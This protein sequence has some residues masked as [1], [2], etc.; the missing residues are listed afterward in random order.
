[1]KREDHYNSFTALRLLGAFLVLLSHSFDLLG[2]SEP[3]DEYIGI[4]F[5]RLGLWIFF[6]ISGYLIGSSAIYSKNIKS[7]F[8]KR[9]LRIF[10][11]LIVVVLVSLSLLGPMFTSYSI[12]EYF[13][14]GSTYS[15]F[16]NI[17]LYRNHYSLPGVFSANPEGNVI[18]GSLWTLAY[19]FSFYTLASALVLLPK[20]FHKITCLSLIIITTTLYVMGMNDSSL[21]LPFFHLNFKHL[22]EFGILFAMGAGCQLL[23]LD[24]IRVSWVIMA[25]LSAV[26]IILLIL[27]FELLLL[28]IFAPYIILIGLQKSIFSSLDSFGD[29]SYGIYLYSFPIQQAIIFLYQ[30][31][32]PWVLLGL[33]GVAASIFGYLSWIIVEKPI[34][35]FKSLL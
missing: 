25:L 35:K 24:E 23:K 3:L 7:Y 16:N 19:E 10:P 13:S 18:N 11:A 31:I 4:K 14:Q 1:M 33:A 8:W 34:L 20:S 2:V 15:Y 28:F 30:P 12:N 22:G 9:F 27:R 29:I 26:F 32:S 21:T 17:L 5:S 6:S